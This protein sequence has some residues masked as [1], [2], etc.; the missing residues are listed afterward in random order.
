MVMQSDGR[1]GCLSDNSLAML[2]FNAFAVAAR[3]HDDGY[4]SSRF[5]WCRKVHAWANQ[6]IC[7]TG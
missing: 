1:V 7:Q 2:E 6:E 5:I 3:L 4:I